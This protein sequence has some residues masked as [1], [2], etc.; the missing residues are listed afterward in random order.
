MLTTEQLPLSFMAAFFT[1]NIDIFPLDEN[2]KLSLGYVLK[3]M[4]T[5]LFSIR[6]PTNSNNRPVSVAGAASI[7][8]IFLALNQD[9][10]TRWLKQSRTWAVMVIIAA[11]AVAIF[12][13]IIWTSGLGNGIKA[14]ITA[15]I[16][17]LLVIG[18]CAQV[19]YRL[20]S[21]ARYGSSSVTGSSSIHS[22]V[23]D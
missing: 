9:R 1:I 20:T 11:C 22:L 23:D 10:V 14:A 19:M 12:L 15:C 5:F 17:A 18:L 21:L 8:F 3:Y 6:P 4:R 16:I 13:A 7:P 2:G